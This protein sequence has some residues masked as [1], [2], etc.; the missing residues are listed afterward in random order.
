[1]IRA[2]RPPFESLIGRHWRSLEIVSNETLMRGKCCMHEIFGHVV[3]QRF[4]VL[5][6]VK[7][8][9]AVFWTLMS[10][11]VSDGYQRFGGT[12]AT[13]AKATRSNNSENYNRHFDFFPLGYCLHTRA[14]KLLSNYLLHLSWRSDPRLFLIKTLWPVP[15]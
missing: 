7:T 9:I 12:L 15:Q 3:F 14:N 1:V 11:D 8:S 2:G 5:A 6:V 4:E 10:C 13:V